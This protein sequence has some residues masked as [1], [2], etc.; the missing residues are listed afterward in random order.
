M[1]LESCPRISRTDTC[2]AGRSV[3]GRGMPDISFGSGIWNWADARGTKVKSRKWKVERNASSIASS[4]VP[5][6]LQ[7]LASSSLTVAH[8]GQMPVT[9]AVAVAGLKSC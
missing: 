6:D 2:P 4:L 9:E 7:N 5:H 3:T 1:L 8:D